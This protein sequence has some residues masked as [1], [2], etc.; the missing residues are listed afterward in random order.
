MIF[1]FLPHCWHKNTESQ[2][3]DPCWELLILC[4]YPSH[5]EHLS[6]PVAKWWAGWLSPPARWGVLGSSACRLSLNA[7]A[8]PAS[9]IFSCLF[10]LKSIYNI[11]SYSVDIAIITDP[12]P[13]CFDLVV[14]IYLCQQMTG[15]QVTLGH[16]GVGRMRNS[17]PLLSDSRYPVDRFTPVLNDRP[18]EDYMLVGRCAGVEVESLPSL[19][20]PRPRATPRR[21]ELLLQL[22][23]K[24]GFSPPALSFCVGCCWLPPSTQLCPKGEQLCGLLL[25]LLCRAWL[26]LA[27]A[28]ALGSEALCFGN[29]HLFCYR[30]GLFFVTH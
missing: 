11:L 24:G 2:S 14:G 21:H 16:S 3:R 6:V 19:S 23:N 18:L 25:T 9:G 4:S 30:R 5:S 28:R 26:K 22:C 20:V 13:S 7:Q 1:S 27:L 15:H 29:M 17:S 10:A 8:A 12:V